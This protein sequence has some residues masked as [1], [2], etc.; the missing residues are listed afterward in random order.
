MQAT[1]RQ[2]ILKSRPK[3]TLSTD[4]FEL[5]EAPMPEPDYETGRV[6]VRNLYIAYDAAMRG[7]MSLKP[8]YMPPVEIGDPMRSF[9]VA[10]VVKSENPEL[11]LGTLLQGMYGWQDYAT[12]APTDM[13]PYRKLN[14][15]ITPEMALGVLGGSST[16]AFWGLMD[17][18]QP[19]KGETVVVSGAAGATGSVAAQIAKLKGCRVIGIAGGEE[20]CQWLIDKAGLDDAID[21][22]NEDV[23][24]RLKELCPE[25]IDIFY[26]NVGGTIL[27]AAINNIADFGRIVLCGAISISNSKEPRVGPGNL[28]NLVI[29]RV[30]MQGFIS[31]DYYDRTDEALAQL[32]VWAMEDKIAFRNDIQEGFDAIPETFMRLFEGRNQGKQLL[33]LCDPEPLENLLVESA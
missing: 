3:G 2:W 14:R 31:L 20:K 22:K 16:T 6:L 23:N 28:V 13:V 24:E 21:Y 29:R 32:A 26:D 7:W 17:I 4:N 5:V 10:Q 25:G 9:N 11:P 12:V 15:F 30:R 8:S 1:N 33:K 18:G 27:E 19:K